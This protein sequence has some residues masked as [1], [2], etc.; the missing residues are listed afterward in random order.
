MLTASAALLC[1]AGPAQAADKKP[2]IRVIWGDGIGRDDNAIQATQ[3]MKRLKELESLPAP[4][5]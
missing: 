2:N 1:A 3:A 5:S 4:H